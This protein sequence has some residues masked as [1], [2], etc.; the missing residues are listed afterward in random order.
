MPGALELARLLGAAAGAGGNGAFCKFS[1]FGFCQGLLHQFDEALSSVVTVLFLGAVAA[2]HNDQD[3]LGIDPPTGQPLQPVLHILFERLGIAH[4]KAQLHRRGD[5]V[6]ILS[7]RAARLEK[8][9]FNFAFINLYRRRNLDHR[10]SISTP[11]SLLTGHS[12]R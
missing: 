10:I 5:L 9:E 3:P 11:A 8:A 12:S 7:T 4:I 2:R 1:C 6:N